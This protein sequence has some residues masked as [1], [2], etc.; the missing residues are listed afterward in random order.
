MRRGAGFGRL[1][2]AGYNLEKARDIFANAVKH[3]PRIRL[4]IGSEQGCW[5][6]SRRT[7]HRRNGRRDAHFCKP[8]SRMDRETIAGAIFLTAHL[9]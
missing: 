3:R 1:L 4:T 9:K 6:F 5:G 8:N 2:Y 7:R